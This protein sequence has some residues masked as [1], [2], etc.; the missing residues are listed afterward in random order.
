VR[1]TTYD[2][3]GDIS[4]GNDFAP[5][6]SRRIVVL[7]TDGESSPVQSGALAGRL[8]ASRGYRFVAIQFWRRDESVFGTDG[9]PES[10]YRPDPSSQATLHDLTAALGGRSFDESQIGPAAAY[11]RTVAGTGPTVRVAGTSATRMPLAPYIALLG[12]LAL[13][14]ALGP[15]PIAISP[16]PPRTR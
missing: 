4:S 12:L 3:L 14:A 8:A 16:A 6:A 2:A 9:K 5:S 7:L 13:L 10:G 1:A 11:L 15:T